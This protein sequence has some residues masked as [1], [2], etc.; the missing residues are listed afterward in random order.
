[1]RIVTAIAVASALLALNGSA[2]THGV[3]TWSG[4]LLDAGCTDRSLENLRAQPSDVLATDKGPQKSPEGIKVDPQTLKAERAEATMPHTPD[5]ASRYSSASCALTA[6]TKA[7]LLLT[8][9]GKLLTLD[10]G[11][12]TLAFEAFQASPAGAAI[13]NGK[14]GGLK[15]KATIKGVLSGGRLRVRSLALK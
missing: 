9:D 10:E 12:N 11:G 15:P 3:A 5:H 14:V 13:L 4:T 1:M 8:A 6:D 2:E 7:F